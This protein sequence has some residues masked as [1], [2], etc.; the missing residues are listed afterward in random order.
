M[1]VSNE[2]IIYIYIGENTELYHQQHVRVFRARN[3]ASGAVMLRFAVLIYVIFALK[4]SCFSTS[5]SLCYWES[6]K[7][8]IDNKET[9]MYS[10]LWNYKQVNRSVVKKPLSLWIL[11]L[12]AGDV[13]TCPG[14]GMI[15]FACN[16]RILRKQGSMECLSCSKTSVTKYFEKSN[17]DNKR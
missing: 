11:L 17:G 13:E 15:C 5:F 1:Y 8:V 16:K 3:M 10:S 2:N 12:L 4:K 14:P 7:E 6:S 9:F